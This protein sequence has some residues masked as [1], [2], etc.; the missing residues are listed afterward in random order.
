[1]FGERQSTKAFIPKTIEH[2]LNDKIVPVYSEFVD[3]KL[4]PFS[5]FYL[6]IKNQTSAIKFL[7]DYYCKTP[8]RIS[9]GL[10]RL[11]K[12]N[13][14]DG[15]E[16]DNDEIVKMV[17]KLLNVEKNTFEYVNGVK[18]RP[19]HDK[20]YDLNGNKLIGMGWKPPYSF[21]ESIEKTVN[22]GK[23]NLDWLV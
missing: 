3:G 9:D 14:T 18:F 1:M 21:E 20:R 2:I 17:A 16:F 22:W 12:F 10:E 5:R 23:N 11:P 19:G 13:I 4:V 8:H 7:I 15:H 6:Y